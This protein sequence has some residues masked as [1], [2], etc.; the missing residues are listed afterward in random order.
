MNID[1]KTKLFCL[2]GHPISKTLSPN[3]HNTSFKYNGLNSIYLAFDVKDN[4]LENTIKSLKV[5]NVKGYNV[6]IP[7]KEEIIRYLDE[8]SE[9]AK[10]MGA[11]NTVKFENGKL[12][13]YNTDGRGFIET[14]KDNS[15]EIRNIKV[16]ILGAGGAARGISFS[17]CNENVKEITIANRTVNKA[18]ILSEE[19]KSKHD[20]ICIN[21]CTL[22]NINYNID[23]DLVI[24][25]T[26]VGMFPNED[27]S[28]IDPRLLSKKTVIYD[29]VYKP[30]ITKFLSLAKE[31]GNKIISGID[32]LIYQALISEEIWFDK[33][34]DKNT[35]KLDIK[36]GIL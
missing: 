29:I 17:L 7:F 28:P 3:I 2:I 21:Y 26:S 6:T 9:E 15:V 12:K 31:N 8:L 4:N 24:N 5:L 32:M 11:V 1:Y 16:L 23:Y 35:I 10:H 27:D 13:G 25:C 33:K 36:R 30:L 18:E 14:L 34:I 20:N 22:N 19:I